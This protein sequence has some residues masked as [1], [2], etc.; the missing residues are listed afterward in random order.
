MKMNV[1]LVITILGFCFFVMSMNF[2]FGDSDFMLE[3]KNVNNEPTVSKIKLDGE[4]SM[5]ICPTGKCEIE[6]TNSSFILQKPYN[7]TIIQ[8][9]DFSVKYS[10]TEVIADHQQKK[11]EDFSESI[12]ACLVYDTIKDKEREIYFCGDEINTIKRN[13]D[14]KPWYYNFVGIYD[15]KNNTFIV[16]GDFTG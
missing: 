9:L 13:S 11:S 10:T 12:D 3:L 6:V 5:Q 7:M 8:T 4:S 16:K 2:V 15:A 1:F 14:S